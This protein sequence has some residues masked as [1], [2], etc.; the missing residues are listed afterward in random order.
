VLGE[1]I[2]FHKQKGFM[3]LLLAFLSF[4]FFFFKP[5]VKEL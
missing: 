2:H 1:E 5:T 3:L 4:L